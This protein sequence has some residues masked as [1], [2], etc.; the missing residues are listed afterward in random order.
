MEKVYKGRQKSGETIKDDWDG[1]RDYDHV[2]GEPMLGLY[3]PNL[4]LLDPLSKSTR[5]MD[6]RSPVK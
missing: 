5:R 3:Y 4:S 2:L 6:G 1:N